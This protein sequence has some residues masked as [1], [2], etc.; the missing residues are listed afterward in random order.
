MSH[1]YF[2]TESVLKGFPVHRDERGSALAHAP[3]RMKIAPDLQEGIDKIPEKYWVSI[4]QTMLDMTKEGVVLH[5]CHKDDGL[6]LVILT[7]QPGK[8]GK[9]WLTQTDPTCRLERG[10]VK[11]GLFQLLPATGVDLLCEDTLAR[12]IYAGDGLPV[13][14]ILLVMRPGAELRVS[15]SGNLSGADGVVR[16]R[17][18]Y[19]YW[20]HNRFRHS[21]K[22]RGRPR[23]NVRRAERPRSVA[24]NS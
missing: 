7:I 24:P 1:C 10:R 23:M 9:V 12:Q 14:D 2:V 11:H 15:R 4:D 22:M 21:L 20:D 3:S 8:G 18:L 16:P 17:E 5:R 6:A 19:L 13:L